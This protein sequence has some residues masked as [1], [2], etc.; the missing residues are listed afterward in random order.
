MYSI[1]L[2]YTGPEEKPPEKFAD[3][4]PE[5]K[6]KNS[7]IDV[8]KMRVLKFNGKLR[9]LDFHSQNYNIGDY[10]VR[11]HTIKECEL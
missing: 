7:R 9:Y 1:V 11:S 8:A 4:S 2:V 3:L 5:K 10:S 6:Q